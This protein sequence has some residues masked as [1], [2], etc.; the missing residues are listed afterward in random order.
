MPYF[1]HVQHEGR[2]CRV[3]HASIESLSSDVTPSSSVTTR[4]VSTFSCGVG[5]FD[6][7]LPRP[8]SQDRSELDYRERR[9]CVRVVATRVLDVPRTL[10]HGAAPHSLESL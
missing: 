4:G 9:V 5:T 8:L 10:R 7:M 3:G 2:E 6:L 1:R